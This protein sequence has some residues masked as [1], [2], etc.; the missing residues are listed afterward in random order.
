M[1]NGKAHLMAHFLPVDIDCG[2]DM[3]SLQI[4][5]DVVLLPRFRNINRTLVPG[6]A[7]IV[8]FGREEERELHG[9][10]LPILFHIRIKVEAGV[11]ERTCPRG[12][13]TDGVALAIGQHRARKRNGFL[14]LWLISHTEIPLASQ[15]YDLLRSY[16]AI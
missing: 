5:H 6:I 15:R 8:T 9:S 2:L 16:A 1:G 4:E 7:N 12:F 11:V 14:V 3:W 10:C 13:Y